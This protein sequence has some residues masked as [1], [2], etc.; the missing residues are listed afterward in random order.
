MAS[1]TVVTVIPTEGTRMT[2]RV[3]C[4]MGI[5][6]AVGGRV[7]VEDELGLQAQP[8]QVMGLETWAPPWLECLG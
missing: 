8:T 6:A 7:K 5:P 3:A 1:V 4:V 2:D